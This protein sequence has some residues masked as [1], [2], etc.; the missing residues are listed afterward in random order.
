MTEGEQWAL[1]ILGLMI[2]A[3]LAII[4]KRQLK[5]LRENASATG[6]MAA[7]T[8]PEAGKTAHLDIRESLKVIAKLTIE[9]QVEISEAT[10]RIKV[11]LD[12]LD[13]SLHQQA[14]Y[15]VFAKVHEE[16]AHM[17]THQARKQM[18]KRFIHKLDQQRFA[19][20][21]RYRNEV[22]SAAE[23]LLKKLA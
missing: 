23:A 19:I 22:K 6:S 3:V 7:G 16:L 17:P 2:I 12:H 13:S 15:Q 14:P 1:V 9:D 11:L 8:N 18:D 4:I 5:G 21:S 10:I 20:E